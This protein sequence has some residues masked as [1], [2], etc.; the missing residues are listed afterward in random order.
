MGDVLLKPI[1]VGIDEKEDIGDD[2]HKAV[3]IQKTKRLHLYIKRVNMIMLDHIIAHFEHRLDFT[4]ILEVAARNCDVIRI[5]TSR[6]CG[7]YFQKK[8]EIIILASDWLQRWYREYVPIAEDKSHHKRL[9]GYHKF[10]SVSHLFDSMLD[11]VMYDLPEYLH[12]HY[13]PERLKLDAGEYHNFQVPVWLNKRMKS[14]SDKK[15]EKRDSLIRGAIFRFNIK[16]KRIPVHPSYP[17]IEKTVLTIKL[18][19][20]LIEKIDMICIDNDIHR[21]EV[22]SNICSRMLFR[23]WVMDKQVQ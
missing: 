22:F 6:D 20:D 14:Y 7:V 17:S 13:E 8:V 4:K 3:E 19:K 10:E 18:P 12:D 11:T 9:I 2:F 23:R 15:R 21:S 16:G 5:D 1:L